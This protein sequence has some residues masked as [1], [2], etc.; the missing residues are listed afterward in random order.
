MNARASPPE[1]A[2]TDL[3]SGAADDL[4]GRAVEIVG[5]LRAGNGDDRSDYGLLVPEALCCI[6]CVPMEKRAAVEIDFERPTEATQSEVRLA[7]TWR[8]LPDDDPTCWIYQ[9]QGAR[10][11]A[12]AASPGVFTRRALLKASSFLC[13]A[14]AAPQ[15]AQA[16]ADLA[17]AASAAVAGALTID[18]HSHAGRIIGLRNVSERPPFTPVAAPMREGGMAVICLTMVADT[19]TLELTP[20]RRIVATREP[21]PGE[22]YAWSRDGFARLRGLVDAQ[23]LHIVTDRAGLDAAPRNG[24]SVIVAAEGADFLEGRM[25]RLEEA[26]RKHQLRH[27][28]LTHYRPNEL[29]DIQ[30]VSPVH[31]GLTDFGAEVIRGCNRM[32]IVVD[33]AHGTFD[34]VKRAASV[35]TKPLVLSHT[36]LANR[37]LPFSRLISPEHARLVAS[38]GGV[39]G[40]WPPSSIFPNL[41]ALAAGIAR[42][43]DVAGIDHVGLGTDMNG[44]TAPPTFASYRQ[45]PALAVALM[46]RGFQADEVRKLLG[47]NYARV[48]ATTVAYS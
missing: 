30:T 36:S 16:Q 24:P 23:G 39:I 25:E 31:G 20:E 14:I 34:L 13:L 5:W 18:I 11:V 46:A 19:P 15:T 38:T 10:V 41:H 40:I 42:V 48:F 8:R 28:Q 7:G 6:G 12:A 1:I 33:I 9:L 3:A 22:F 26:Y 45:L 4:D 27:L 47:G 29:G 44:L 17:A 21:A 43:V 32:G 35:T 37:P 2:W